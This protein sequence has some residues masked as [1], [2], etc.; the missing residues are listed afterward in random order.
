MSAWAPSWLVARV[1]GGFELG[2]HD[3]GGSAGLGDEDVRL[4]A[5]LLYECA[6][7]LG[8]HGACRASCAGE[9][10]RGRCLRWVQSGGA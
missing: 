1:N 9:M 5:G 8:A 10:R 6:D 3:D 2:L 4:E 7:V